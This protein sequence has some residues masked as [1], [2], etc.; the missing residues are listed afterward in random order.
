M[1]HHLTPDSGG[2]ESEYH[3]NN[4]NSSPNNR[5]SNNS[6]NSSNNS[7]SN[8]NNN[9]KNNNSS[10]SS[11][12]A[13]CG[14]TNNLNKGRRRRRRR[15][16]RQWGGGPVRTCAYRLMFLMVIALVLVVGVALSLVFWLVAAQQQERVSE[17]IFDREA[18]ER[19][20]SI[21][22]AI[23]RIRDFLDDFRSAYNLLRR[24]LS[25]V[26]FACYAVPFL[27]RSADARSLS[28][29]PLIN[30][31]HRPA[32]EASL[33]RRYNTTVVVQQLT[34]DYSLAVS[35]PRSRYLPLTVIEPAGSEQLLGFDLLSLPQFVAVANVTA[36]GTLATN[37]TAPA[38]MTATARVR[39]LS[40]SDSNV[41]MIHNYPTDPTVHQFASVF[42]LPVYLP[43]SDHSNCSAMSPLLMGYLT[44][45]VRLP[46]L[47]RSSFT[48][49]TIEVFI[50]DKSAH[51]SE[52]Y[53]FQMV[54]VCVCVSGRL[55]DRQTLNQ[56]LFLHSLSLL[57]AAL[58]IG[59][60][61]LARVN[62]RLFGTP[63]Q[64]TSN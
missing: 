41:R 18:A 58:Y 26:E 57:C 55:T 32:F 29:A 40:Q 14:G 3:S 30:G 22:L 2:G 34:P 16:A 54:C 47:V 10:S 51:E 9:N 43:S 56:P 19:T 50:F 17:G 12:N 8:N 25:N 36:A 49:A 13:S 23:Y 61:R 7:N 48:T 39:L 42:A 45:F 38:N 64:T 15:A 44:A 52:Q 4:S 5:S 6:N 53:L 28:F 63:F 62:R 11:N 24:R 59:C 20:A 35:Q 60:C 21:Q 27:T 33:S 37:A 1:G 46:E 31:T